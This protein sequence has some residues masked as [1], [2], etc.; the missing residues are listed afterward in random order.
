VPFL[1]GSRPSRRKELDH[2]WPDAMVQ[3]GRKARERHEQKGSFAGPS[4]VV[5]PPLPVELVGL[6]VGFCSRSDARRMRLVSRT[7]D[8]VSLAPVLFL[9]TYMPPSSD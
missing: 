6:I 5:V 1:Y 2:Y 8:E 3:L 7:M 4:S 9:Y